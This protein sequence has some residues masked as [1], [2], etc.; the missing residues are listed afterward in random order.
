MTDRPWRTQA[1]TPAWLHSMPRPSTSLLWASQSSSAPS[2]QPTSSTRL[3]GATISAMSCRSTRI[4]AR[5]RDAANAIIGRGRSWF[6]EA[7][8]LGAAVEEA[9]H[10]GEELGLVQQEGVVALVGC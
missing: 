7:P 4:L 2:P 8:M 6:R 10:G 9:F 5:G 1:L 3:P